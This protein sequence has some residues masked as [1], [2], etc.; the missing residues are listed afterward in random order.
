MLAAAAEPHELWLAR[1]RG[2]QCEP[3]PVLR[4][5]IADVIGEVEAQALAMER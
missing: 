3:K 2:F 4:A 1:N 5:R